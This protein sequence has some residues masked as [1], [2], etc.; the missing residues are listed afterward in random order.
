MTGQFVMIDGVAR[1]LAC[2]NGSADSIERLQAVCEQLCRRVI[3][4]SFTDP[5]EA[6]EPDAWPNK[7]TKD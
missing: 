1:C 3:P 2:G 7:D 5:A 6:E 4:V